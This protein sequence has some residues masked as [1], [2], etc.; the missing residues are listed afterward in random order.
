[1]GK[2]SLISVNKIYFLSGSCYNSTNGLELVFYTVAVWFLVGRRPSVS[3]IH[4]F[5]YLFDLVIFMGQKKIQLIFQVGL[6]P[7]IWSKEESRNFC[8]LGWKDLEPAPSSSRYITYFSAFIELKRK[9]TFL[10]YLYYIVCVIKFFYHLFSFG[11]DV[12][13]HLNLNVVSVV[14]PPPTAEKK[15]KKFND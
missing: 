4:Y 8:Y 10:C 9:S 13:T 14:S 2:G 3:F 15:T 5:H 7:S 11:A 12:S 6:C 1:M